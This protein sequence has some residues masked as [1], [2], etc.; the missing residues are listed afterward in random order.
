MLSAPT[1]RCDKQAVSLVKDLSAE[2][3]ITKQQTSDAYHVPVS[4]SVKDLT[5]EISECKQLLA[6]RTDV[7][8]LFKQST[9]VPCCHSCQ[10]RLGPGCCA[11]FKM[12]GSDVWV[13]VHVNP[14]DVWV[15]AMHR[16]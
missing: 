14:Q 2:I 16:L 4:V 10:K 11:L 13:W 6:E 5:K 7:L 8:E 3:A 12:Q 9:K 1:W 15:H